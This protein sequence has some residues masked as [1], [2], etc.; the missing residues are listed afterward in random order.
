MKSVFHKKL[1]LSI[2]ASFVT[3]TPMASQAFLLG[4]A[5]VAP[6]LAY[7]NINMDA[8]AY[9]NLASAPL[10]FNEFSGQYSDSLNSF[11]ASLA[12][13]Y[14]LGSFR[15]EAELVYFGE[16]SLQNNIQNLNQEFE[17]SSIAA[18]ANAYLDISTYTPFTPY[19]G[20]GL[21][22]ASLNLNYTLSEQIKESRS[23]Q[24]FAW[25]IGAG[26]AYKINA[27]MSVD[28]F[29]RYMSLGETTLSPSLSS[30]INNQN[31]LSTIE[32]DVSLHQ[33]G[34]GLRFTF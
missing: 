22:I 5:Y 20:G 6:K 12:A 15:G 16:F 26:A 25:H 28:M 2:L 17:A 9:F 30:I 10:G 4:E 32:T 21:G 13:G 7:T 23:E 34:L 31:L 18:F 24:N 14:D 19:I 3:I 8:S 1:A 33:L 29:Y 27:N 11:S